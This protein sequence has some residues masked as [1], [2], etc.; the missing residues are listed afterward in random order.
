MKIE[1]VNKIVNKIEDINEAELMKQ[2]KEEMLN[3]G[4]YARIEII[5]DEKSDMPYCNIQAEHCSNKTMMCLLAALDSTKD[6]LVKRYP[7]LSMYKILTNTKNCG[8]I[9]ISKEEE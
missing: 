9:D 6:S 1:D 8:C 2:M 7:L 5:V 4:H 3:S